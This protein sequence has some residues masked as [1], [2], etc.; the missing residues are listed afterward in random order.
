MFDLS[1]VVTFSVPYYFIIIIIIIRS[2]Q[3]LLF[4]PPYFLSAPLERIIQK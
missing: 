1:L 4:L 3:H 2:H